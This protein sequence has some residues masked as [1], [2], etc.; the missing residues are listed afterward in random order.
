MRNLVSLTEV[1]LILLTILPPS[2]TMNNHF[3]HTLQSH[4]S[5][6]SLTSIDSASNITPNTSFLLNVSSTISSPNDDQLT[7]QLP[8]ENVI[9]TDQTPLIETT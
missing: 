7:E 9:E 1:V 3:E 6:M 8:T 2:S 4:A 5:S